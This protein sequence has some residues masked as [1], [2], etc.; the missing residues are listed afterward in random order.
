M[1]RLA[2]LL[3]LVLAPAALAGAGDVAPRLLVLQAAD[4]P[5][6]FRLDRAD[7]G[8]RPNEQEARNDPRL[9]G[10]FR[11]W[12]RVTGYE[13]EF[14]RGQ[15][16]ISSRADLFRRASGAADLLAWYTA[17]LHRSSLGSLR[18]VP[19]D[20]GAGGWLYTASAP[21][22]VAFAVWRQGRVFAGVATLRLTKDATRRLARAQERRIAAALR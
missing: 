19:L 8:V 7:S 5:A 1:R 15:Q 6:G 22:P 4:V 18:R 21:Q 17:E 11:R 10:L 14:D 3:A 9:P 20:V 2:L 13:S 12:G 16:A